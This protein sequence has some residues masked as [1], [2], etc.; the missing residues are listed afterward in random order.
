MG[1]HRRRLFV[2]IVVL[3]MLLAVAPAGALA[4]TAPPTPGSVP[5]ALADPGPGFVARET[6]DPGPATYFVLH[7]APSLAR[8]EGGI[9]G[10]AATAP[11]A[12]GAVRLDVG[13]P[14]SAA[15][16]DY[17]AGQHDALVA[18]I[19]AALGR[20]LE[21]RFRYTAVLN[22]IAVVATP[23]EALAISR[24]PGVRHVERD[25][26][27]HLTTDNGPRW[28][29]ADEVWGEEPVSGSAACE[30]ACGEGVVV[31][32]IDTGINH[33]H[34][35]FADLGGDGYD[36]TNPRG[37]FYGACAPVT[38]LP[39]CNDKLIGYYDF[40]GTGPEDD[41]G[42][43]SHTASTAAG[44]V[45]HAVLT[46]PTIT[47]ERDIAGVAP[48]ANI[49]A[50]KGCSGTPVGCQLSALV[51]SINQATLDEVDVINYSIGGGSANP[52]ED[53]DAQA[54][55]DAYA[56][57]IFVATSA[58]NDGPGFGTLGSPADAPWVTSVGASTHDR[59]LANGIV[60]MTNAD[61][62]AGPADIFGKSL[63]A[64]LPAA[65]VVYA[66]D[67]AAESS[68]P[69]NA[70]LCGAGVGDPATGEGS[71]G[72]PW[73]A[74]TFNGE[75]VVCERGEYGRVA[76]GEYVRRAGAGGYVLVNDEA[77]GDSLTGDP[78]TLPGVHISHADGQVLLDWIAA[79][80]GRDHQ[81]TA[82]ING[83]N[84]DE[85]A[86]YGDVMASFSS[87][88][89]NPAAADLIKPD[90]TAPGVDILAAWMTPLGTVDGEPEFDVISGTSM[91]SPHTAGA[92]ALLRGVRPA[93]SPDEVKSALMTT[94]FTTLPGN[95]AEVHGVLKE[96]SATPADPFDM[97]AGRIDLHVAARAGLVLDEDAADYEAANPSLGGDATALNIASLGNDH[98]LSTCSWTRTIT[99]AAS[100]TVTWT[101][102]AV[103][104]S[105]M[106]ISFDQPAYTLAPGASE[107]ITITAGVDGL[108]PKGQWTFAEVRL[109]PSDASIPA[110][111]LPVA[112]LPPSGQEP[113]VLHMHGNLHDGCTGNGS[114]DVFTGAGVCQPHLSEDPVLDD[115][116]AAAWGP[117]SIVDGTNAQNIYD[118]NWIWELSEPTTL[119]GPM[120]VEYWYTSP[121]KELVFN[122][123]FTIRLF[124]D[125]VLV[126][127]QTVRHN[128]T[129]PTTELFRDTITVPKVTASESYVVQI[130]PFFVTQEGAFI[131]YDSTQP[132]PGT[133][134]GSSAPCDS[135]VSMPVVELVDNPPVA[136]DDSAFVVRGGTVTVD[137]LANDTDDEGP[138]AVTIVEPPLNGTADL[139]TD[140][141]IVYRHDGSAT[142]ADS[143]VYEVTDTA[144]QKDTATVSITVADE[145]FEPGGDYAIDFESGSPGWSVDTAVLAPPSQTWQLLTDPF[146]TSG[147]TV[148]FT[149]ALAQDP[150][151][152]TSKD[153]RLV[154]P[155]LLVSGTSHLTFFHRFRTE[156]GFDGGV[157]EVRANGGSWQDILDAGGAFVAGAYNTTP[158]NPGSGFVLSGR[159]AW[160][161]ES[162]GF[163][164]G[165]M[166]AVDVDLGALAGQTVQFRFRFG[167]D[168][169]SPE[170]GG[171][172]IDDVAVNDL[173]RP[174]GGAPVAND[175]AASVDAGM[176]VNVDVLAN[177]T[178]S[179]HGPSELTVA[180]ESAPAHGSAVVEPDNTIT[181]THNGDGAASDSFQYR[182]TDPD[183]GFDTAT[184]SVTINQPENAPPDAVDDSAS[185]DR[186]GS[187]T[188]D[189]RANDSDPDDDRSTLT[190]T[191][192]TPPAHGSAGVTPDGQ[193]TYTHNGDEATS[194]SFRYRLTDP[195]GAF[196]VATVSIT[197]NQEPADVRKTTGGGFLTSS[198]GDKINFGF[199]AREAAD[200]TLDGE[201]QLNDH[202]GAKVKIH[203]SDVTS[204]ETLDDECGTVPA[205]P[206]SVVFT[207]DGRFNG[208][209]ASFR[210]CVADFGE[211]GSDPDAPGDMFHLECTAGCTYS[212]ETRVADEEIDG[213]NIQVHD[214]Q[215]TEE[216]DA[217]GGSEAAED[218]PATLIL[219]PVLLSDAE[220]GSLQ[221]L[222]VRAFGPDQEA[223]AGAEIGVDVLDATGKLLKTLTGVS[224]DSGVVRVSVVVG[225]GSTEFIARSG[226]LGSNAILLTGSSA[227]GMS[228]VV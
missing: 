151:A 76:K 41:N 39:F 51:A 157:L 191:I 55:F 114:T 71:G 197:I 140:N 158:L 155:E 49:I 186:G 220:V 213:G 53:L 43:G 125:G 118:P 137:V 6:G 206:G 202:K 168:Q 133:P 4:T 177:D 16:L 216:G 219:D 194:D 181:Y 174:C 31:G 209:A 138:L 84:P 183:G 27:R 64:P 207:G 94:A 141:R 85:D 147:T 224:D 5:A 95:G 187:T 105:G 99:S 24:L 165:T 120:T 163:A 152:D 72:D 175:D 46:A 101:P 73:P 75:I 130:D 103:A 199:N 45:L 58:G 26:T 217:G 111:H 82:E 98:C 196:D 150:A 116:P 18:A 143:L 212:T 189:V 192:E 109:S 188:I 218:A 81:G 104:P 96:D 146:A 178:D 154:S 139:T 161:G 200:G 34:P 97:G 69:D 132:C 15:Y 7:Q 60:N 57:G 61:G 62:S 91:S 110:V 145:C 123:D 170:G 166:N 21:V 19:D 65:R 2:I 164:T 17:L 108:S 222:T 204:F 135:R 215:A 171:W 93:W 149:D 122:L 134:A 201:L 179:D 30:G 59:R 68:D 214:P 162:S 70:H 36:H 77:N 198:Q 127:E 226:E 79:N 42:H 56:A 210:V 54:F 153:V 100:A 50:Y 37:T 47:L 119:Q 89:A 32:I 20:P 182:V 87:R 128:A 88:G 52:W 67:Y 35:S 40:T 115:S 33:D 102:S 90:V 11:D 38:G 159:R 195:A 156:P 12:T 208:T 9:A 78:Y 8:Y 124:A 136:N 48:H 92:A 29:G 180:I 160:D 14:A 211:P 228:A 86:A 185:V 184:V 148:W 63:T 205:G 117:I 22:G 225:V 227:I 3:G 176:S 44:N 193:V 223:L 203:L 83:S 112:V 23:D 113:L 129:L 169:L 173:L 74:G 10:L 66:G 131:Y 107:E 13:A 106:S 28:I 144:G 167:Q 25:S 80:G 190:V 1:T 172:W 221:T 121:N 142:T 126:T